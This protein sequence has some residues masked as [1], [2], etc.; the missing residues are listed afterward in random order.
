MSCGYPA[1]QAR[2]VPLGSHCSP[3]TL[4]LMAIRRGI[5][6][7]HRINQATT[8]F[9]HGKLRINY[10]DVGGTGGEFSSTT[11]VYVVSLKVNKDKQVCP[12][13]DQQRLVRM[14]EQYLR[15]Y[16]KLHIDSL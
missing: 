4:S 14:L 11:T 12:T 9:C 15:L 8:Q 10:T 5:D 1:L 3:Y 6:A 13:F 16:S 7:M 2:W